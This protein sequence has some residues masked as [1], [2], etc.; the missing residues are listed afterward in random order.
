MLVFVASRYSAEHVANKLY[1]KKIN[2]TAF[3]GDL[4]QGARQ[5]VLSE[6]KNK[7]WQV[8]ITTDLAARGIHVDASCLWSST[9]TCRA[10]PSSTPTASAAQAMRNKRSGHQLRDSGREARAGLIAGATR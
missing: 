5:Q 1:D 6:F 8:L 9:T 3:H 4:S 7:Q 2:A 10:R